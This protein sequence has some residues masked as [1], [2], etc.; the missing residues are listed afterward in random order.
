MK[1]VWCMCLGLVGASTQAALMRSLQLRINLSLPPLSLRGQ[2]TTVTI[3]IAAEAFSN[4]LLNR[5][6][7]IAQF[8]ANHHSALTAHP[9]THAGPWPAGDRSYLP[10]CLLLMSTIFLRLFIHSFHPCV[11]RLL[12]HHPHT[13]PFTTQ[14]DTG[15]AFGS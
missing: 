2:R 4:P 15:K 7:P 9:P 8:P 6:L 11:H 14:V 1:F 10:L 12:K 13:H 3:G 5:S